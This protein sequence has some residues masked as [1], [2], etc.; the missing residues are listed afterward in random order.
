MQ[1]GKR[2]VSPSRKVIFF[3]SCLRCVRI[4]CRKPFWIPSPFDP[5]PNERLCIC[6]CC[7][8]LQFCSH[9]A[10]SCPLP[11]FTLLFFLFLSRT[12]SSHHHI[13]S[14]PLQTRLRESNGKFQS[15]KNPDSSAKLHPSLL[16]FFSSFPF[17]PCYLPFSLDVFQPLTSP[18]VDF[19]LTMHI[20]TLSLNIR[21]SLLFSSQKRR[22]Q[23]CLHK[24]RVL[25][26]RV[27]HPLVLLGTLELQASC[28][29]KERPG[30]GRGHTRRFT[31]QGF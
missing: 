11:P 16:L 4:V 18:T 7:L 5:S 17:S 21:Y 20:H 10:Q 19:P 28:E 8:P 31:L 14:F 13:G 24:L 12:H 9:P 2:N 30:V 27:P 25:I 15:L 23:H 29:A 3:S 6:K 22:V 1:A 26:S